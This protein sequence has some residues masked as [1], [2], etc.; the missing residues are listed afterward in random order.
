MPL[1]T[2]VLSALLL[3]PGCTSHDSGRVRGTGGQTAE[4]GGGG[5][6]G[7]QSVCGPKGQLPDAECRRPP[8][9]GFVCQDGE[10]RPAVFVIRNPFGENCSCSYILTTIC[11]DGCDDATGS[12]LDEGLGG[13]AGGDGMAAPGGAA[14]E[15][16]TADAGSAGSLGSVG[17]SPA[18]YSC[19]AGRTI[20]P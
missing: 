15:H 20:E 2:L 14:G 17:G 16:S 1:L 7:R 12:C 6:G 18:E 5:S 19:I 8:A 10:Y 9:C 11:D 13:A 4:S 3:T